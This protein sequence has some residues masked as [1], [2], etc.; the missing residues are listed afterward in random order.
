MTDNLII[1]G[2]LGG[3]N[4]D[5]SHQNGGQDPDLPYP[6]EPTRDE[7]EELARKFREALAAYTP[8]LDSWR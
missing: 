5:L 7:L 4:F 1:G 2:G 6:Q 3:G 8:A